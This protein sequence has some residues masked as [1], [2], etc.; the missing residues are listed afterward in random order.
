[1]TTNTDKVGRWEGVSLVFRY[2][3]IHQRTEQVL[4]FDLMI[5]VLQSYQRNMN[6]KK[7]SLESIRL[8]FEIAMQGLSIMVF[9]IT[10]LKLIIK[11]K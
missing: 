4:N 3:A 2:L 7:I 9:T 10:L 1:M 5:N 6:A 11:R 8:W